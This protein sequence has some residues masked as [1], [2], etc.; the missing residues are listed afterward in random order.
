MCCSLRSRVF[1]FFCFLC[2]Q[3]ANNTE[4]CKLCFPAGGEELAG[5]ERW[6]AGSADGRSRLSL[7]RNGY[8]SP[9]SRINLAFSP[10]SVH[11]CGSR[12][13]LRG[14]RVAWAHLSSVQWRNIKQ[15]THLWTE[16][17]EPRILPTHWFPY[18]DFWMPCLI[19][20]SWFD[21]K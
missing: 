18:Y 8:I 21:C 4:G 9:I 7:G 17:E 5:L 1:G 15:L 3:Q 16:L 11:Q 19:W 20:N 2:A 14:L 13:R 10:L 6:T 12:V